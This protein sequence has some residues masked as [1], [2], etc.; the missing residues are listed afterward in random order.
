MQL[1]IGNLIEDLQTVLEQGIKQDNLSADTEIV[2][3]FGNLE[4]HEKIILQPTDA[5]S[6][7]RGSLEGGTVFF[8][9]FEKR[10]ND[11]NL[12]LDSIKAAVG[13]EKF[14]EFIAEA[15]KKAGIDGSEVDDLGNMETEGNA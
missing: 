15:E 13:E 3:S 6:A 11:I 8:L 4:G 7:K 14:R 5:G 2:L 9:Q 12:T 1:T 10:Q